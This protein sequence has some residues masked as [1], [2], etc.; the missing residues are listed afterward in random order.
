VDE[1][2]KKKFKIRIKKNA[3]PELVWELV[4]DL[5]DAGVD[6]GAGHHF[7]CDDGCPYQENLNNAAEKLHNAIQTLMEKK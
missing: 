1:L 6:Y 7:C 3:V 2:N 4:E 5:M